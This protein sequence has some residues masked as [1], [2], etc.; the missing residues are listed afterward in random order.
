MAE[1][2]RQKAGR[3]IGT[4]VLAGITYLDGDGKV[5]RHR[6]MFGTVLRI[7]QSE[8]LVL[9]SGLDGK[10]VA[11]PPDLAQYHRAEPGTYRLHSLDRTVVDPDYLSTW[12]VYV[13]GGDGPAK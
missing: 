8:G 1:I 3:M 7:N 4:V 11:L 5:I 2:E 12:N 6:Q 9:A 13:A 10:E